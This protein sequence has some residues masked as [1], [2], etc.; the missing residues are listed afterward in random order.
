[1]F[2]DF[3]MLVNSVAGETADGGEETFVAVVAE[4]PVSR[5]YAR[6]HRL[7]SG[8]KLGR[9]FDRYRGVGLSRDPGGTYHLRSTSSDESDDGKESDREVIRPGEEAALDWD[10]EEMMFSILFPETSHAYKLLG[11]SCQRARDE[12]KYLRLKLELHPKLSNLPWE[13]IRCPLSFSWAA[14]INHEKFTVLRYLGNISQAGIGAGRPQTGRRP[15]IL[16]VKADPKEHSSGELATSFFQEREGIERTLRRHGDWVDYELI[17]GPSTLARLRRK[18]QELE[19]DPRPVIGLHYIGHGGVGQ[20]GPYLVGEDDQQHEHRIYERELRDA[21]DRAKSLRWVILNACSTGVEP[22]GCPLAGLATSMAVIKNVPAVIAYKRPVQTKDAEK[23]ASKFYELVLDR[24]L[25]VEDALGRLQK[26]YGNPGGLVVLA[27]ALEGWAATS[28][29]HEDRE[30]SART[31]EREEPEVEITR[32]EKSRPSRREAPDAAPPPGAL[33]GTVLI[34]AGPI[35]KG[36]TGPQIDALIQQFSDHRLALDLSSIR[37]VLKQETREEIE[38]PAFEIDLTPV[39]NAQYR[40]FVEATSYVTLAE[41]RGVPQ[42]W[43][44]NDQPDK[45]D[46]PVVFV[47]YQ[48]AQ[49]YCH[50]AGKTLPTADQWKKAYR[51]TDGNIY[52]W[53]DTFDVNRCNT[54][55]RQLGQTTQVKRF[56]KGRSPYGCYDMVGNVEEWT[57]SSEEGELKVV[58]G[59]SWCMTCQVYGLPVLQRLARPSFYSNELG[60]RCVKPVS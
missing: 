43:R 60:F 4:A 56:P 35:P 58:L 34:P 28:L 32:P 26:D 17:E 1:M 13:V 14:D 42:N 29:G 45:R 47:T 10:L 51:G 5:W 24:G 50:W 16:I 21:L 46:H 27:H 59:G 49:A 12:G 52:P 9:L 22:I 2:L 40:A 33:G 38:L 37:E 54:A 41:R 6:F 53:G 8:E 3:H 36:L 55:E 15:C 25:A 57:S 19:L 18:V 23:L 48:D 44:I 31:E 20:R 11:R 30:R 7:A 39:T